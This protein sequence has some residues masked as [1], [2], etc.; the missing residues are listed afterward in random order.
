M[1]GAP[2]WR[3]PHWEVTPPPGV[4]EGDHAPT[5]N[6]RRRDRHEG[7][8]IFWRWRSRAAGGPMTTEIRAGPWG[9]GP[10]GRD[11]EWPATP[12]QP[13]RHRAHEQ[14]QYQAGPFR[15]EG[16]LVTKTVRDR[17]N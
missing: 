12:A 16:H 1:R 11:S 3:P 14:T 13:G 2:S 17:Q 6:E 5:K 9:G 4:T 7:R 15:V 8:F 10:V